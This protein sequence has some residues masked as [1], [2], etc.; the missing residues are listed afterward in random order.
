MDI[1]KGERI[2]EEGTKGGSMYFVINGTFEAAGR[3]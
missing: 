2:I 1:S 3:I